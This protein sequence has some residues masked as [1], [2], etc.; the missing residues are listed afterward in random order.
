MD[1]HIHRIVNRKTFSAPEVLL[2]RLSC[3]YP[4]QTSNSGVL[5]DEKD[6][7]TLGSLL[8]IKTMRK[9][10]LYCIATGK[11]V[12]KDGKIYY[13]VWADLYDFEQT[14]ILATAFRSMRFSKNF[15]LL[16]D[17]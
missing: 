16:E 2:N 8:Y 11:T 12:E 13:E 10:Q 4:E 17:K 14:R 3:I 9:T 7:I 1:I 5:Y 15:K 6:G